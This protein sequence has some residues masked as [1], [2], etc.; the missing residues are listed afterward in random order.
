MDLVKQMLS[1]SPQKPLTATQRFTFWSTFAYMLG[2]L[3]IILAPDPWNAIFGLGLS[4]WGR[5]YFYLVGGGLVISGFNLLVLSRDK[6][7][8]VPGHGAILVTVFMRLTVANVLLFIMYNKDFITLPFALT[9]AAIDSGFSLVTYTIWSHEVEGASLKQFF[10]EIWPVLN[11]CPVTKR[12][13]V[14]EIFRL[15]GVLQLVLGM[16]IGPSFLKSSG[17]VPKETFGTHDEGL[18]FATLMMY[19]MPGWYQILGGGASNQA[20]LIGA[21]F[22]RVAWDIPYFLFLGFTSKIEIG[23]ATV[24]VS[25]DGVFFLLI[26]ILLLLQETRVKKN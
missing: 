24:L 20:F 6:S 16:I 17:I 18:L 14:Y 19:S 5:G 11:P 15:L 10:S 23:L 4:S 21:L 8:Q 2:G 9:F 7:S 13:R 1:I 26:L 22:Y 12:E 3:S 25:F